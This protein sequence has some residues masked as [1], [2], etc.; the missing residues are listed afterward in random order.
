MAITPLSLL[1]SNHFHQGMK[2]FKG[3]LTGS[4]VAQL[5]AV[6]T[7]TNSLL[8]IIDEDTLAL[9]TTYGN[10][11]GTGPFMTFDAVNG[12]RVDEF[13][14]QDQDD[15]NFVLVQYDS[16]GGAHSVNNF[17]VVAVP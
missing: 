5:N 17:T 1:S 9:G 15:G 13:Q 2:V 16:A 11:S 6:R 7:L 3:S 10:Y 8:S 14:I 12:L 4:L